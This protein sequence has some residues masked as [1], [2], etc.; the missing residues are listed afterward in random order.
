MTR[1]SASSRFRLPGLFRRRPTL[2]VH[3]PMSP[4]PSFLYQLRCLTHSLRRFGGAYRDS[5]VIATVGGNP[6]DERLADRMPWL[7]ANGIELRWVPADK[8]AAW[9]PPGTVDHR[10]KH[11]YRSDVVLLLDAD[12][13]IRRPLDDLIERV[14]RDQVLAGTIAHSS[15]LP[16]GKLDRP[17]WAQLFALCGLPEPRLEYEHTAW[18]YMFAVPDHRHCPAYFNYGV[19]AAP[20]VMVS[21]IGEVSETFFIRL[22]ETMASH[23]DAQIV[24]AMAIARLGAPVLALP[25]RYNMP[26]NPLLEAIHHTEVEHA[27][28][29]H[30]LA[31]QHFRRTETFA[32][33]ASL[34][35]FVA[36]TD[37][38]V[39]SRMAQE[40]IRAILPDLISEESSDVI[41]A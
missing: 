26:N 35:A 5:P 22:R 13:L 34:E 20:A 6:I 15:P 27:T 21:R 4:T 36:R 3:V 23:F 30:L 7:A 40:I 9:G 38:R 33:L 31:E 28:V 14:H 1:L 12:T 41:A 24:L 17:D 39:V 11:R 10:L 29:L 8:F 37:L 2:E 19:I 32:S 25:L 18:G 16:H